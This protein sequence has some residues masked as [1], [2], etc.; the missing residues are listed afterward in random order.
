MQA[1]ATASSKAP[2]KHASRTAH[3]E[4]LFRKGESLT[5]LNALAQ[6]G[7]YRLADTVYR[8][9][10]RGEPLVT[11]IRKDFAGKEYAEYR[12]P[13]VGD[14]VDHYWTVKEVDAASRTVRLADPSGLEDSFTFEEFN[15]YTVTKEGPKQ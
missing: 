13:R 6:Y 3:I 8:L 14:E 12:W 11:V 5:P 1:T 4:H 7:V 2:S 9:R 10:Q 15:S